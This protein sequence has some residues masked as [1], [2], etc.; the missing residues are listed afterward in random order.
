MDDSIK[1]VEMFTKAVELDPGFAR[2]HAW[3]ACATANLWPKNLSRE[4]YDALLDKGMREVQKALSLDENECE[5]HRIMGAIYLQRRQFDRAEYHYSKAVALN[6]NH[7]YIAAKVAGFLSYTGR[8]KEAEA[9]AKR[10]M[11]LN[12]HHPDWYWQE[13][14]LAY[15]VGG[16]YEEAIRTFNRIANLME[17]DYAYLAACCVEV[18]EIEKA[19]SYMETLLRLMPDASVQYYEETQPFKNNADMK[20]LLDALRRA[21]LPDLEKL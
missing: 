16:Q 10:S 17:F 21:G 7:A 14:G 13:L 1:A 3:L 11:R 2:A 19:Q 6:P 5:A 20:R 8:P 12:P 15:Y 4:Q 18:G 9:S